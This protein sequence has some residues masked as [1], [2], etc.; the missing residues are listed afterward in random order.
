[1]AVAQ[2]RDVALKAGVSPA[3]V[4]NVLNH[5]DKVSAK[6]RERVMVAIESLGYVRNDAA[7]QLRAGTNRA[8]GMVVL[9]VAN[10]FFTELAAGAEDYLYEHGRPLLLG[11][12]TQHSLREATHL[13]LFEQQR[14]EGILISP[15]GHVLPHLRRLKER[16]TAVVIVDRK[17]GADEFS[18]V[19]LDDR[20]GGR[21]MA[22]H[23]I[24]QGARHI[25]L[26]GGPQDLRQ[27]Q[28][29]LQ[30]A[31]A[32]VN[33]AQDV[34]FELLDTGAMDIA[35]GRAAVKAVL[36]RPAGNRPDA[37]FAL[38][39]LIALG[40]LQEL[41][42]AGVNVPAEML[43]AGYD[44]IQFAAS[45]TIPITSIRQPALS[46]GQQAAEVLCATIGNTGAPIQH[47]VFQPELIIREST[48]RV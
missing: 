8:V 29:R 45:A 33:N 15:V 32:R 42:R 12:S 46:M 31:Q 41:V 35:A 40:A 36:H 44:D 37:I 22:G 10:P 28:H 27:V 6:T 20:E 43:L 48:A 7:R 11:N 3:T 19:S 13:D 18:S 4:S 34:E 14:V 39:D 21:M 26:L 30:G 38:N 1:M 2:V 9:D 24:D 23:L 5:P 16:G 17:T 25:I 47:T